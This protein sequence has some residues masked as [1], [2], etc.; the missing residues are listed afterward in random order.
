MV[1]NDR[2]LQADSGGVAAIAVVVHLHWSENRE[3]EEKRGMEY[4]G[5]SLFRFK[6]D[7]FR[8]SSRKAFTCVPQKKPG[9]TRLL[10][11]PKPVTYARARAH[12][13]AQAQA[14]AHAYTHT[15]THT[16]THV[17][18]RAHTRTHTRPRPRPRSRTYT[19]IST[20]TQK[21]AHA[22]AHSQAHTHTSRTRTHTSTHPPSCTQA[23]NARRHTS[24]TAR[25]HPFKRGS[26]IGANG[27]KATDCGKKG[28]SRHL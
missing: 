12:A 20:Q 21:H 5:L 15:N 26:S 28:D 17:H 6:Q 4:H 16:N 22:S 9:S 14:H 3:F 7:L 25:A 2:C 18:M 8:K 1:E 11:E 10:V 19:R 23:H 24:D 27:A 13:Q